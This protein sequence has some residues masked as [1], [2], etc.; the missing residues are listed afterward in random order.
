[1]LNVWIFLGPQEID[2]HRTL[3]HANVVKYLSSFQKEENVY[4]LMELC[5]K[6]VI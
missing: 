1:M 6:K 3:Q 2:L 5:E 4:I